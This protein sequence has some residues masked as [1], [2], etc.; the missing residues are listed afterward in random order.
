ML[1]ILVVKVE[2]V[3]RLIIPAAIHAD[4]ISICKE[5]NN[6]LPILNTNYSTYHFELF[7][8]GKHIRIASNIISTLTFLFASVANE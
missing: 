6:C 7:S 1:L 8:V 2:F 4:I 3:F 5:E